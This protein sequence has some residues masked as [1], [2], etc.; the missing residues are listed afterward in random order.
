MGLCGVLGPLWGFGV[1]IGLRDPYGVLGPLWCSLGYR[2]PCGVLGV[3]IGLRGPY[4]V[5]GVS[6]GKQWRGG[7]PIGLYRAWCSLWGPYM[8]SD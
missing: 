1:P 2:G 5:L 7:V 3:S 4:G 8:G 6:M